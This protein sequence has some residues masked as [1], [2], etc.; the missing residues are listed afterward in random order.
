MATARDV[1][2]L[3]LRDMTRR[4]TPHLVFARYGAESHCAPRRALIARIVVTIVGQTLRASDPYAGIPGRLLNIVCE[5]GDVF[6]VH[7][8]G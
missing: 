8:L 1:A 5:C 6:H 4:A 7:S 2:G 3:S